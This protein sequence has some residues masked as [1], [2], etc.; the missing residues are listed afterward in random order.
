MDLIVSANILNNIRSMHLNN[1]KFCTFTGCPVSILCGN[2]NHCFKH[3][4]LRFTTDIN[5]KSCPEEGSFWG[6][7]AKVYHRGFHST[8]HT[9][10]MLSLNTSHSSKPPVNN[11]CSWKPTLAWIV[12][13]KHG[14]N[15]FHSWMKI[16]FYD[17]K[18]SL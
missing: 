8:V 16:M 4:S 3:S 10:L 18:F 13:A 1:C 6:L 7:A 2:I 14:K 12:L 17:N 9:P 5:F 11:T 15:P